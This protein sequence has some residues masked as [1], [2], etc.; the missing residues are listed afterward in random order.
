MQQESPFHPPKEALTT[1]P[2]TAQTDSVPGDTASNRKQHGN[3]DLSAINATIAVGLD[4]RILSPPPA[5]SGTTTPTG[6]FDHPHP[7]RSNPVTLAYCARGIAAN[8][9][10]SCDEVLGSLILELGELGRTELTEQ[11][12][13]VCDDMKRLAGLLRQFA[14]MEER[15]L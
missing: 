15:R 4:P 13:K 8:V 14:D 6:G 5:P 11:G 9:T 2:S 1:T 12:W 7:L 3:E 10:R